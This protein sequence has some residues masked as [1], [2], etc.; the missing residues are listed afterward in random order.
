MLENDTAYVARTLKIV[1]SSAPGKASSASKTSTKSGDVEVLTK[2]QRQNAAKKA[3]A[4]AERIAA[5]QD[6]AL[7]FKA[8]QKTIEARRLTEMAEREK[9]ERIAKAQQAK[10]NDLDWT[11]VSKV[12][13]KSNDHTASLDENGKLIWE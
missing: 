8:H 5:A 13:P 6:Q 10:A 12:K 4:K 3:K 1:S 11:T 2:K 9:I 7:A